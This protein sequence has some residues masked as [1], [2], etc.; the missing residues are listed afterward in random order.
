MVYR[1]EKGDCA[2]YRAQYVRGFECV[3]ER[4]QAQAEQKRDAYFRD[5]L[6]DPER[7]RNDLKQ[8]LGWPLTEAAPQTAPVVTSTLL[9]EENGYRISRMQLEVIDGLT[10]TGLYF[11]AICDEPQPLV[12]VQ[13]GGWGTP[14]AIS[15]FY[16]ST[17]NYNEI[18]ERVIRFG[19]HAFAPQLL[20]W[21]Q[22]WYPTD[23]KYDRH[24]LDAR[25]KRVGSSITAVEV[26][27]IMRAI[28]WFEREKGISSFGMAGLSYGGFYT[29]MTAA[30]DTRIRSA[31]S[32]SFFN[33]RD[34]A[35]WC[36]WTWLR[37][38]ERFDDAELACMV[39]PRRLCLQMGDHDNLFDSRFSEESFEKVKRLCA[40]VGTDWVDL[41][42]FDGSHEFCKDDAPIARM[43]ADLRA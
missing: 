23:V 33:K 18:L 41:M 22:E 34:A 10:L 43:V 2:A 15:G 35:G 4:L 29:L 3:L 28:D 17:G 13:H 19:V 11:E 40:D 31:I 25:L 7:Y 26:Y 6:S 24:Q 16:G 36:D 9:A 37:S 27:A 30:V 38:A 8:M 1:E 39:Y 20:L 32:C 42:I 14:E 5:F 12:V 21:H